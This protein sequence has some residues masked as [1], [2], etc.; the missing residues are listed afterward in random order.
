MDW[1]VIRQYDNENLREISL[2]IGGI[3]TG[4][5]SMGGRG[6]LRD[7]QLMGRPNRGWKPMYAHLILWTKSKAGAKMRILEQDL[8]GG[9]AGDSGNPEVFAA[10]P[11]FK[12]A[13]F[14]ASYPF[15]RVRLKDDDTPIDATIEAWNPLIPHH[16]DDSSLPMGM[17]TVT[18]KNKSKE[19]IEAS[20]SMLMCN[21]IG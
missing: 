9:F 3:G 14:E 20:L 1:P 16:T 19:T 18:L 15:G 2:P 7:F 10:F 5:F 11:R 4:F 6:D 13:Q 12:D 17:L 8:P 21:I